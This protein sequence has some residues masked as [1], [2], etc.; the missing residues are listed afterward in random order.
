MLRTA[1]DPDGPV[2]H[3]VDSPFK[4]AHHAMADRP[5]A[6]VLGVGPATLSYLD[7]IPVIRA[8]NNHLPVIVVA[9]EDS[10]ELER[11]ARERGIFYYLVHPVERSEARAVLRN[12][13]SGRRS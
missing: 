13:M 9:A 1:A 8:I 6:V 7:V 10:L 5:A 11:T 4:M 12:V 2:L 3:A